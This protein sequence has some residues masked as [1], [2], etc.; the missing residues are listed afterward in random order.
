MAGLHSLEMR[1]LLLLLAGAKAGVL[2][3][4]HTRLQ[5]AGHVRATPHHTQT[6]VRC[7]THH[8]QLTLLLGQCRPLLLGI[9]AGA[10]DSVGFPALPEPWQRWNRTQTW[11]TE[12]AVAAE[13]STAV[14]FLP[15]G[16]ERLADASYLHVVCQATVSGALH[17]SKARSESWRAACSLICTDSAAEMTLL[18]CLV[19]G[20]AELLL[21]L[22]EQLLVLLC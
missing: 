3:S 18:G 6:V 21:L 12:A 1:L 10:Q 4:H 16:N 19:L 5:P 8:L 15:G 14:I 17:T 20:D 13:D 9:P 11:T 7:A 22:L 2:L